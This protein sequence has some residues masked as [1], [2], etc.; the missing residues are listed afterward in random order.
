MYHLN[1][2]FTFS[3]QV[4]GPELMIFPSVFLTEWWPPIHFDSP[5]AH[6]QED[7]FQF[8]GFRPGNWEILCEHNRKNTGRGRR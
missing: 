5:P 3:D 8:P 4:L 1:S 6:D 7:C 2:P